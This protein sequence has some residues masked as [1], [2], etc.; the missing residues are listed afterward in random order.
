M[1]IEPIKNNTIVIHPWGLEALIRIKVY[2]KKAVL[3]VREDRGW[4]TVKTIKHITIW[5][6][7][8]AFG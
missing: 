6:V 1:Y 2:K 7:D 5:D 8:D 3:Q 4:V